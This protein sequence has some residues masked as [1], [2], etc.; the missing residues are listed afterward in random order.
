MKKSLVACGVLVAC[1]AFAVEPEVKYGAINLKGT[2]TAEEAAAARANFNASNGKPDW[3]RVTITEGDDAAVAALAEAFPECMQFSI[4]KSTVTTLTPLAKLKAKTLEVRYCTVDDLS[5]IGECATVETVN[6]YGS[7]VKDFAP[8]AKCPK[9]KELNFYATK[10]APEVYQTLGALKQCKVFTGGLSDI[11]TLEWVKEVPQIE[12]LQIFAEMVSDFSPLATAR[13]LKKFRGWNMNNQKLGGKGL[14]PGLGDLAFLAS[15]EKLETLELPG[16]HYSNLAALAGLKN[17]KSIDLRGAKCDVDLS[18]VKGMDKLA[19]VVA[20]GCT[21]TVSGFSALAG[22]PALKFC[23]LSENASV[24]V[25]FAKDCPALATLQINGTS[26]KISKVAGF[27]VLG[28]VASLS[29]LNIRY[30]EG[31][32]LKAIKPTKRLS[33]VSVAKE[34]YPEAEIKELE[35]AMKAANPRARLDAR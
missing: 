20:S 22:L 3:A 33:S 9:L 17:L 10:A 2:C 32:A 7:T 26:K 35:A 19:N 6:L 28:S 5:P 8:L 12:S 27:D 15:C 4:V 25:A 31:C 34:Q 29:S 24:D 18:F 30:T 13:N 11:T 23:D 1:A 14:I 21:G 16:S